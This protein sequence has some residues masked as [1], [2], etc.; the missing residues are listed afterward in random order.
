MPK[1]VLTTVTAT[2]THDVVVIGAGPTG[3]ACAIELSRAGYDYVVLEKGA[4]VNS[5]L[6]FPINMVYFTTPELLEIG[7]LPLVTPHEKPTRVEALKYYR[8]VTEACALRV[9]TYERVRMVRKDGGRFAV[10][11]EVERTGERRTYHSRAV[12]VATGYYDNPKVMGIPGEDL[13]KV[14]H[15]Y[16]EAHPFVGREVMVIGAANSAAEAALD[17]FRGGARVTL[18]HRRAEPSKHLKYWV[19]P[20]L[21]NRIK[22]GEIRAFFE[23]EAVE[24]RRDTVL[25]RHI[26]TG[27]MR[28]L[29]NDFV[30]ALTGYRADAVFLRS[31]GIELDPRTERPALNADTL[32][33]N[34]P[35]LYVA[36]VA[37]AGIENHN[38]FIEN[39]R[40][41]GH[42]IV[43]ALRAALPPS[44]RPVLAP[45][46][47]S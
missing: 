25:T 17:L 24:I 47:E 5:L 41:H 11:T 8:K 31:M 7:G 26:P 20:D 16:T 19:G 37:I 36:G 28:E 13:A 15:Y 45:A 9:Q 32:E 27:E 42:Q 18:L 21:A 35:G 3:L 10:E 46:T 43:R 39:G 6:H 30:F 38:V 44:G 12:I 29:P 40:F 22:A 2:A 34:V 14:S 33:S 4:L 1:W 23:T